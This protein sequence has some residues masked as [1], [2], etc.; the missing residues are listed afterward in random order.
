[1]CVCWMT[2]ILE[3]TVE[4]SVGSYSKNPCQQLPENL[5]FPTQHVWKS[6]LHLAGTWVNAEE[7]THPLPTSSKGVLLCG[8]MSRLWEM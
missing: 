7:I 3:R 4:H 2:P 8:P 5:V 6:G 1:M